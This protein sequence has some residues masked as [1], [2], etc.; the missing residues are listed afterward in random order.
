MKNDQQK[1]L[2]H[3][4]LTLGGIGSVLASLAHLGCIVWGGDGYRF[5]GAGEAM[6]LAAERGDMQ[7]A[8][9]TTVIA[10]MLM[11]WGMYAFSGAGVIRRLPLVRGVLV[12]VAAVYLLR[13]VGAVAIEPYFPGN[14]FTFWVV[15]SVICF[16]LGLCYAVGIAKSWRHLGKKKAI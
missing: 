6:A 14:S 10:S 12:A 5:F 8:I 1:T 7:P 9:V 4:W 11:V 13:G 15:S 16:A 2:G 3:I